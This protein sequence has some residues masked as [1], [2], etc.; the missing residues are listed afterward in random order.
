MYENFFRDVEYFGD[1]KYDKRTME[2]DDCKDVGEVIEKIRNGDN[3]WKS[4]SLVKQ[5]SCVPIYDWDGKFYKDEASAEAGSTS[6]EII[7]PS[8]SGTITKAYDEKEP[9]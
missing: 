2:Y 4:D 1:V 9:G 5:V 8:D 7:S 3:S 6:D